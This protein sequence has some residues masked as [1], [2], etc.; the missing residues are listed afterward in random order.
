MTS[1]LTVEGDSIQINNG[2]ITEALEL[3]FNDTAKVGTFWQNN[4][5]AWAWSYGATPTDVM[6]LDVNHVLNLYDL[7]ATSV[8]PAIVLNPGDPDADPVVAPY[9]MIGGSEVITAAN[10]VGLLGS[11]FVARNLENLGSADS[12]L[13]EG[14]YGGAGSAP[15]EGAGVRV[16]WYPEKAAFRAGRVTGSQWDDANIGIDSFAGG[17]DSIASGSGAFAFGADGLASGDYSSV[18]GVNSRASN[19]TSF[20]IGAFNENRSDVLEPAA[21]TTWQGDDEHSVLEVGIG[22]GVSDRKNALTVLQDGSVEI[23]KATATDNSV[24]LHIKADGSIILAKPQGDIS[25]G[26]YQ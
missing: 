4:Q 24:P 22:T 5:G 6:S 8:Y 16:M 14:T 19:Y 10:G 7:G 21:K 23:G 1:D 13:M 18:F 15:T 3:R 26:I 20:T 2:S 12:F 17:Y 25:M 9:I 11:S